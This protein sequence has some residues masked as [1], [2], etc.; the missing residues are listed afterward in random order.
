MNRFALAPIGLV[1]ILAACGEE[2]AH[3]LP[4]RPVI[5]EILSLAP[6][7]VR[8][9]IGTVAAHTETDLAFEV[10]GRVVDRPV[11][12]GDVVAKGEI[13]ARVDPEDL[14]AALRS[15]RAVVDQAEARLRTAEDTAARIRELARRDVASN[16][17]LEGAEQTLAVAR[18]EL[19]QA[20]ASLA[21][22]T[23]RLD[24]TELRAAANG[25]VTQ[26]YVAVGA[27]VAAGEP[28]L[29]VAE[30]DDRE[31]VID[32][33]EPAI[34]AIG[35]GASFEVHLEAARDRTA[36]GRL[37]YIEPVAE[38]ATRTRRLHI[39]LVDPPASF[40]LGALVG[41]QLNEDAGAILSIPLAAV[42]DRDG[43]RMAWRVV[44]PANHVEAVPVELGQ[45]FGDRARLVSGLDV[46]DEIVT[47]GVHSLADGKAVG[48]RIG[49]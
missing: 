27:T 17:E 43:T 9:W 19:A 4:P 49:A 24:Y 39:R 8:T 38:A 1:L 13:L 2:A 40:R 15:A 16:A 28:V 3:P 37:A 35:D 42:F 11:Q 21:Q 25:V 32:L 7:D 18:S 45:A 26:T 22:A 46:G 47:R 44:R 30:T 29:R 5:S 6:P 36:R 12:I 14:K 48:E 31:A 20:V 33:P 10:V 34:A 41:V 23:E